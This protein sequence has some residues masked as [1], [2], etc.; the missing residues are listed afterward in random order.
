MEPAAPLPPAVPQAP[1]ARPAAQAQPSTASVDEQ[2][3]YTEALRAVS[4]NKND[5][6][7]KKFND[8]LAKYPNSAKTPEALYWIGESY[9]GDKSYNQAILSFKDV[10][11][12]FPKDPKAVEALYRISDAYERLGDKANAVFNLKLLA[13]EHPSSE[14]AGKARQKLK[15]LGQ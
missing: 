2:M 9:M 14:F 4:S 6:G 13:D 12:R 5:E 8:F 3:L 15:Q 11:A 7:R 1:G 10:T